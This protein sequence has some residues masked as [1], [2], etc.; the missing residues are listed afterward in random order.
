MRARLLRTA[1]LTEGGPWATIAPTHPRS[2]TTQDPLMAEPLR[3]GARSFADARIAPVAAGPDRHVTRAGERDHGGNLDTAIRTF[4]GEPHDWI[5]LS[6]GIN[7]LP[8]AVPSLPAHVWERLPTATDMQGLVAAA[9]HAYATDAAILPVAGAQAA[10]QLV[11][12]LLPPGRAA[13][14]GPTYDEHR[15]ALAAQGWSVAIVTRLEDLAGFDLAVVVNPNNP[16]GRRHS[17]AA[18]AAIATCVGRLIVDESFIDA[19]PDDSIAKVAGNGRLIVLRSFGKFYGLAGVRLGFV[20]AGADDIARLAELAGPWNVSGA[21][22]A[23]GS[24]ALSDDDWA[25]T[26]A[27][28]LAADARRLDAIAALHGWHCAG[29]TSLFRLYEATNA[30]AARTLL[31]ENRIWSRVFPWSDHLIR[32]GLP[33]SDSEW[34]RLETTLATARP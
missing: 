33:G 17:A 19:T 2:F 7:R 12:R 11:P 23:I 21:A 3:S 5:D 13:V 26:T 31:A 20:I 25:R 15:A 4:G 30:S 28:R 18:L 22:I 32:L 10:I 1:A 29:G 14:L 8:Y 9:A 16:D 34:H 6:T 24:I 27:A